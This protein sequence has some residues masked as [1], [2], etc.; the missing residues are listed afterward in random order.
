M[1]F[2]FVEKWSPPRTYRSLHCITGWD[3]TVTLRIH[4]QERFTA[5]FPFIFWIFL[6]HDEIF[7]GKFFIFHGG[8]QT[9]LPHKLQGGYAL[10]PLCYMNY[11]YY[12]QH[13]YR[14]V[15]LC[16]KPN[17][18][19]EIIDVMILV[20][21]TI[22]PTN[23]LLRINGQAICYSGVSLLHLNCQGVTSSF[24]LTLYV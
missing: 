23:G 1:R 9:S 2:F 17:M 4:H 13:N 22:R 12:T 6:A 10:L 11:S 16:Q 3:W 15:K 20:T 5:K 8:I 21:T 14:I 19:C 24:E 7:T 18:P